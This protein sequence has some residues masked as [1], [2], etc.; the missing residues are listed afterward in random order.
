MSEH[1]EN[2]SVS[3][4]EFPGASFADFAVAV[5]A[6]IALRD[7]FKCTIALSRT[8]ALRVVASTQEIHDEITTE[9]KREI[10]T[11]AASSPSSRKSKTSAKHM[12]TTWMLMKLL[13]SF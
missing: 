6:I 10:T 7:A 5:R 1:S 8:R 11:G 13:T 9:L 4:P 3:E 2:T 12:V